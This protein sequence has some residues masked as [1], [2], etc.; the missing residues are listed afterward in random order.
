MSLRTFANFR[1]L[2]GHLIVSSQRT[3]LGDYKGHGKFVCFDRSKTNFEK[4]NSEK[5]K[6]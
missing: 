5:R 3:Q 4:E 1:G 2:H 6:E